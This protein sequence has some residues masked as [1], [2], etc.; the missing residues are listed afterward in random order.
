MLQEEHE[1]KNKVLQASI[2]RKKEI[3]ALEKKD[4]DLTRAEK[5]GGND[6]EEQGG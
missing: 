1:I 4:E 2:R 3:R 6:T 5:G